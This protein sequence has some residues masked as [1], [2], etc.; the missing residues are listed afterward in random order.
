MKDLSLRFINPTNMSRPR[1]ARLIE[2]FSLKLGRRVQFF[3]QATFGVWIGLEA[4]PSVNG[5]C[6]RPA[7]IGPAR[8]DSI[9]DF[10]VRRTTGEEFL[11]VQA[12]DTENPL[13]FDIDGIP[14]RYV[15][16]VDRAASGTLAAETT[17]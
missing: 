3:D 10:W 15:S 12:G 6:E 11:M 17:R 9:I 13:A 8:G 14:V 7:R 4:D 5:L 2:G 1:G 16:A